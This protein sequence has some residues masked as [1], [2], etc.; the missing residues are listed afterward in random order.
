MYFKDDGKGGKVMD[1]EWVDKKAL[2]VA[3]KLVVKGYG[4]KDSKNSIKASQL[5]KFYADVKGL[6]LSWKYQQRTEEAFVTILPQLKILKAK[7]RYA[8]ARGVV[9]PAFSSWIEEHVNAIRNTQDFEAFLLHFEAV[10]GFCY[11]EGLKD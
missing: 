2:E 6:E 9:P 8:Q 4:G 5:R 10:V 3:K 1:P 7:S 11:G